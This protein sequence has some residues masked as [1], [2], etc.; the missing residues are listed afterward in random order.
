MELKRNTATEGA[1]VVAMMFV[2]PLGAAAFGDRSVHMHYE[3]RFNS[4]INT[5]IPA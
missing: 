5:I 1:T 3:Y 2:L 4:S